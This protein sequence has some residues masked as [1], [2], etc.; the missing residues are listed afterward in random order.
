MSTS[1]S[2]TWRARLPALVAALIVFLFLGLIAY[3]TQRS[4]SASELGIGGR[5]NTAGSF[6]RFSDRLAPD[7]SLPSLRNDQDVRLSDYRGRVVILNF[8]GSWCPPCRE[9][10]PILRAFAERFAA[11]Q[12]VVIGIDVWERDWDDGRRFLDEFGIGYPNAYD[13]EG[14]V[15]IDYGVSGV[16]ETFVIDRDGRLLGKYTGPVKSVE[17]LA[18]LV[19]ELG[20]ARLA[21]S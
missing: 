16:P 14:S 5:I 11:D 13:R 19:T 8:W 1:P 20:A 17:Q 9:E 21:S 4:R 15:T 2:S 12:V 6:V 10:A 18:Q 3:A 7:F